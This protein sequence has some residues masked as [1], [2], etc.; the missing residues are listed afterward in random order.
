MGEEADEDQETD[1]SSS[2]TSGTEPEEEEVNEE[3]SDEEDRLPPD[4]PEPDREPDPKQG[5][6]FDYTV[7]ISSDFCWP[8]LPLNMTVADLKL[9]VCRSAVWVTPADLT[10]YQTVG[11]GAQ[12]YKRQLRDADVLA[13]VDADGRVFVTCLLYTSPSP[14]DS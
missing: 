4:D 10:V 5:D 8:V 14:R 9:M 7:H 1:I 12:Q 2:G 13:D 3:E 6:D 11:V